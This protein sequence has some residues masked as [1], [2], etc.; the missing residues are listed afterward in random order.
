MGFAPINTT[1]TT[2]GGGTDIQQI[3][4]WT[5]SGQKLIV[6]QKTVR[7]TVRQQGLTLSDAQ[8]AAAASSAL[9][10]LRI[11]R[12]DGVSTVWNQ[13][14]GVA[15]TRSRGSYSQ[16]SDSD[17]YEAVVDT[18]TLYVSWDGG[19]NWYNTEQNVTL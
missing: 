18:E 16:M 11:T 5:L 19:A 9:Y 3:A 6:L 2:T 1:N 13:W 14:D 10:H 15:G 17:L 7:S 8:T 4:E 12:T